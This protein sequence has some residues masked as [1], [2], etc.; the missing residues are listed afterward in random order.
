MIELNHIKQ[1]RKQ[2]LIFKILILTMLFFGCKSQTFNDFDL[3]ENV[4]GNHVD[5]IT[6]LKDIKVENTDLTISSNYGKLESFDENLAILFNN[7]FG[8]RINDE[9]NYGRNSV[10]FNYKKED[11]T[12]ESFELH[13]YTLKTTKELLKTLH[14]NLGKEN[15]LGFE[16][17]EAKDKNDF[18]LKI[19]ETNK[20]TYFLNYSKQIIHGEKT[21]EGWLIVVDNTKDFLLDYY[22]T[23][24]GYWGDYL[25]TRKEKNVENYTYQQ[26]LKDEAEE[27]NDLYGYYSR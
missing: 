8:G 6:N 2:I 1:M 9:S 15:Y 4:L 22:A 11:G 17:K 25:V 19:W 14:E 7:K 23:S 20:V 13:T 12:I 3:T 26:F 16:D 27:G 5:T 10:D 21:I 18:D 24:F